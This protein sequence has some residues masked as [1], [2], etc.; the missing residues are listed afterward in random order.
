MRRSHP[1]PCVAVPHRSATSAVQAG[2]LEDAEDYARAGPRGSATT[3]LAA[4]LARVS[5]AAG[6]FDLG[7]QAQFQSPRRSTRACRGEPRS[8]RGE[9]EVARAAS[10]RATSVPATIGR[11]RHGVGLER[12]AV[13]S[14]RAHPR[15]PGAQLAG[16][17]TRAARHAEM[18]ADRFAGRCRLP[19]GARAN[20]SDYVALDG[21]GVLEPK[22]GRPEAA[23]ESP[24]RERA[25]AV[26]RACP[27][28]RGGV[29]ASWKMSSRCA[30]CGARAA[31]M[32]GPLPH[33]ASMTPLPTLPREGRVDRRRAMELPPHLKSLN[34]IAND[35]QG[36]ANWR[37][38]LLGLE[39]W[40]QSA[41]RS[42]T[43]GWPAATSSL[44]TAIRRIQQ[45]P[46]LIR[47]SSPIPRCSARATASSLPV[48][49]A[50]HW[51]I[52]PWLQLA[53]TC[54]R[55]AHRAPTALPPDFGGYLVTT[56]DAF[57]LPRRQLRGSSDG[58]S[59]TAAIGARPSTSWGLRLWFDTASD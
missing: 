13:A 22:R 38:L 40:A 31:S 14:A 19:R 27:A 58:Q 46:E 33:L 17:A 28:A 54:A 9:A 18:F 2:R 41:R 52:A 4:R 7:R 8:A 57:S 50:G 43:S 11:A 21:P 6:E 56:T 5:L 34:Q 53:M 36:S 55:G 59:F 44:P 30:S 48:R 12:E 25:R 15:R 47:A 42:R 51:L 49:K 3:A 10:L 16:L 26:P 1:P 35:R 29:T 20:P 24:A 45:E 23:L 32:Y 37:S 39:E